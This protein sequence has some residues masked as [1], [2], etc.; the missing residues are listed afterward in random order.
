MAD[1]ELQLFNEMRS[2]LSEMLDV[3]AQASP[4][5]FYEQKKRIRE[6]LDEAKTISRL[7]PP[8]RYVPL[9]GEDLIKFCGQTLPLDKV[10]GCTVQYQNAP[11]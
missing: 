6:L 5:G 8:H 4:S 1:H 2:A 11:E 7:P 3:V 9:T 10:E